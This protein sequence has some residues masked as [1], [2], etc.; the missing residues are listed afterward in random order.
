MSNTQEHEKSELDKILEK[1]FADIRKRMISLMARQEKKI[2][3]E[4][5]IT[6]KTSK[7]Y[8]A[9]PEKEHRHGSASSTN[10]E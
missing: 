10:S 7:K 2:M 8:K 4:L 6:N 5:K 1:A 9:K 3:K